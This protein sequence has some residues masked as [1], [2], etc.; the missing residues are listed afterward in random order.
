[1][2]QTNTSRPS[3]T[4][5]RFAR[6]IRFARSHGVRR[7]A[8]RVLRRASEWRG[9][10]RWLHYSLVEVYH[11]PVSRLKR[12]DRVPSIF[13]IRPVAADDM[14]AVEDYFEHGRVHERFR[15][16]DVC[17]TTL[18]KGEMGAGVWFAPGECVVRD[19]WQALRCA[20]R[21]PAGVAWTYDGKGTKLGAWGAMMTQLPRHLER[22]G[23]EDVYTL[24]DYDNRESIDGH[25]S[26]GYRRVGIVANLRIF[27]CGVTATRADGR[28]WRRLPG[29]IG[30]I[31]FDGNAAGDARPAQRRTRPD[32]CVD[33]NAHQDAEDGRCVPVGS[34]SR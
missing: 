12:S 10:A 4:A 15:R 2:K 18:V 5:G 23:V 21:V 13:T 33:A 8:S 6:L 32:G 19:D 26:L 29:R 20:V 11:A 27:G 24:I 30:R 3:R 17:L 9:C 31:E 34:T 14:P 25:V 1:M 7:A 22:I 28:R 16:G